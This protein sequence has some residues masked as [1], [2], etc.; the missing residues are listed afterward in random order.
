MPAMEMRMDM[1]TRALMRRDIAKAK[2]HAEKL[3]KIV[4][5]DEWGKGYSKAVKGMLNALDDEDSLILKILNSKP[6][7]KEIEA[8]LEEFETI[9]KQNFRGEYEKGYY[10][11]WAEFLKAYKTRRI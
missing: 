11:A 6:E 3:L 10:T 9:S 2:K 4:G 7:S 5:K 1:L 8:Y